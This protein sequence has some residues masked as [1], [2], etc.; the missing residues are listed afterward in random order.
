MPAQPLLCAPALVDEIV[1][2]IDQ[3]L[4]LPIDG[5][6]GC[7]RL[8]SGSRMAARAIASASIGSDLPRVRPARR[9]GTVNFGGT[10]TSC[11]PTLSSCRSSQPVSCRPSST[12]HSR[13]A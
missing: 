1:A 10:R 12:A 3:Q 7:G 2:V 6:S 9:S 11:S 4:E 8:R 13:S 5:S